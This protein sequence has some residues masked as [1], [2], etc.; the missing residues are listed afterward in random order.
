MQT[1]VPDDL[2]EDILCDL[3]EE[4]NELYESSEQTLIELEL[5]PED[6]ELQRALFRSI[7]TIKGDLG[8]V[9]FS[10]MIPLLQHVEDLL[11]YLR[12]GQVSYTSTMSDLVLLTMD[13]VKAFVEAVMAEGKAEYDDTL[14]QQLV[15]A[16]SRITPDNGDEHEKRLTEAVLLLNPALDVITDDSNPENIQIKPPTLATSGIPKDMSNE[17]KLDVLFFRDLMQT[18]EKRSKFWVG[19]GDRVAK[20]A[21][22]INSTAGKPI[23]ESQLAVASYVHDFGMAFM[24]LKLLHKSEA[25]TDIEFNLMRSHVYKSSRLLEHLDQWDLARKIVMQHHERTDGTGYPL[26]LKEDDICD[27]AKLLAIVDTYDA[28][29]HSRAH[30][31]EKQ[32]S[33]KEA[34]IEINRSAKG[35]FSMQWVRLFNQAMTSLLKKGG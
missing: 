19:R 27:G 17:K 18:I 22:Y 11:D 35:Q 8:L 10:P 29:T 34:V 21:L 31:D 7:H 24:P 2:E 1:F 23:D 28:M 12:K 5:R 6:N 14:H 13:R 33:K 32:L 30:N 26:G 3:M 16:I 4:I 25:L 9:N 20:L 15:M